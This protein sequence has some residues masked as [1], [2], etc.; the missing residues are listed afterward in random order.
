[1]AGR[2]PTVGIVINNYNYS[3]YLAQA[4]DSALSQTLA[5]Q[6]IV[7]DDGSTDSSRQVIAG[8]G[9]RVV[10]LFKPNGGQASAANLGF[11]RSHA[12][13]VIF[14]DADDSLLPMAAERVAG[15][16]AA[17]P[18]TAKVQYR[19]RV[20]AADGR[21]SPILRPPPHVPLRSGN[22]QREEVSFP[23]D[24]P[25]AAMSANAYAAGVL[26]QI[27]PIPVER[28][29][30]AGADWYLAHLAALC[31]AVVALDEVCALYRVHGGNHY[32][33]SGARLDLDN[34]RQ[35]VRYAAATRA[36]LEQAAD[37][38]HLARPDPITAVSDV[39]G[40]LASLKLCPARH[41]LPDDRVAGLVA[42]GLRA[43]ARRFD[44]GW[45]KKLTFMTWFVAMG[46]APRT[47]ATRLA[48]AFFPPSRMA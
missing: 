40:R 26:K 32:A 43:S 18:D 6:V 42:L 2:L 28:Y 16:F 8:Y 39:A 27:M 11:E 25:W 24:L 23:F 41:P 38:R 4:I 5:C 17:Q 10:P 47:A 37:Q 7:V 36:C 46:L 33:R 3:A 31:G 21:P 13:V 44:I 20:V 19:M 35:A 48:E 9:E 1:V 15:I 14:L 34:I 30:K 45:P 29:D 12:E 22:L